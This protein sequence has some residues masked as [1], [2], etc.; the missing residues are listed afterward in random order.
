[1]NTLKK[2]LFS[3]FIFKKKYF[4][5]V[6]ITLLFST[7]LSLLTPLILKYILD[8]LFLMENYSLKLVTSL[9]I[10]NL[11][12]EAICSFFNKCVLSILFEL[13]EKEFKLKF[14]KKLSDLKFDEYEKKQTDD[15]VNNYILDITMIFNYSSEFLVV[16]FNSFISIAFIVG[17][18]YIYNITLASLS[19]AFL[20]VY[21]I[22][23]LFTRKE[24]QNRYSIL[25]DQSGDEIASFQNDV[26]CMKT[27]KMFNSSTYR[28]S[29]FGEKLKIIAKNSIDK[30][31][32]ENMIGSILY[33][34]S[35]LSPIVIL[36][37]GANLVIK[38]DISIG[39]LIVFYTF[40]S[41]LIPLINNVINIFFSTQKVKRAFSN[42]NDIFKMA[43]VPNI[44]CN[45]K[46]K[47]CFNKLEIRNL[48]LIKNNKIILKNISFSASKGEIVCL[49]GENGSGKTTI[50]NCLSSMVEPNNGE[51]VFDGVNINELDSVYY[52]ERIGYLT[53]ESYLLNDSVFNNITMGHNIS[54]E[55]VYRIC[56]KINLFDIINS[57]DG[58][59]DY[60]I[61]DNGKNFSGG[62]RKL[63]C[64]AR[65]LIRKPVLLLLDEFSN[66]LDIEH[67]RLIY[68]ILQ[69]EY[70][71]SIVIY[72]THS[73]DDLNI[74]TKIVCI[75]SGSIGEGNL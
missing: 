61:K 73:K 52:N 39:M 51:I 18:L 25:R 31:I 26:Y 47:I 56:K 14:Y 27:I 42:I 7:L 55:S 40:I 66:E 54:K 30:S 23:L 35:L 13:S 67:R 36:S 65:I 57:L 41:R 49:M 64:L 21:F 45:L 20:P 59:F 34:I 60:I 10:Y 70:N 11:F 38:Q 62:E 4:I 22:V 69:V 17:T 5:L 75:N 63:I 50:L 16:I 24:I 19:L 43:E 12:L 74:A 68:K 53:Q 71:Q 8:K 3:I 6:I 58:S 33:S 32:F 37:Y 15:Y 29:L 72:V 1:L 28:Y 44:T 9:L 48:N 2:Y 46:N